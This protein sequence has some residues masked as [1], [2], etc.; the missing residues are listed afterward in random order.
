MANIRISA[1]V[2]FADGQAAPFFNVTVI[3]PGVRRYEVGLTG[4]DGT[5]EAVLRPR[6]RYNIFGFWIEDWFDQ[7]AL[8]VL[9]TD[10]DGH[11]FEAP[12]APVILLPHEF[13]IQPDEAPTDPAPAAGSASAQADAVLDAQVTPNAPGHVFLIRRDGAVWVDATQGL[14][15]VARAGLS[16][17]AM[18]N[19]TI[20]HLASM[21]K[22]I[23]ATAFVAMLDDWA[24]IR[25][26]VAALGTVG[27]PTQ[28]VRLLY[29]LW[30]FRVYR[31]YDVPTVLLPLFT[32]RE[33]ARSFLDAGLPPAVGAN[34]RTA[35]EHFVAGWR[36]V[37]PMPAVAPGHFGLLRRVL[38]GVAVPNYADPFLPLIAARLALG[39]SVG[40]NVDTITLDDLLRHRTDLTSRSPNPALHTAAEIAA[41]Q[42]TEPEGGLATDPYWAWLRLLLA[43]PANQVGFTDY[44]NNNFR[45]LTA[46]IE[47]C[48]DT[49]FDDY[50]TRRL[51]FD[52]R[53][54]RIR[55]R[56]VEPGMGA[57]YYNGTAP[58][59]TRGGLLS[60]YSNFGGHG[61]FYGTANQITDWLTALYTGET[62][63]RVGG[64]APLISAI[65]L[66]NLFDTV[67]YFSLGITNRA[68]PASAATRF[69]HNGGTGNAVGAINGNLAIVVTP[70]GVVHA[71]LFV[72]NGNVAAD[73][74]FEGAIAAL[75]WT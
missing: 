9:I 13:D 41:V 28:K 52:D 57:L 58:N 43:E 8:R 4:A 3:E 15:R 70:S 16:A 32:D 20:V 7:P 42:S 18:T 71:A 55:R 48:A 35:L 68:G 34:I 23:T 64:D 46:V 36:V 24:A 38:D 66:T 60:D 61:G 25:D 65:G 19:D 62:V 75:T 21:S 1:R 50:V 51:F 12:A 54:S 31:E 30:I 47:A 74:P 53:F 73:P 45:V 72:A 59:W 26:A 33:R 2:L 44:G 11:S 10:Y 6:R 27:A 56:V 14:A 17:R 37:S 49:T 69:Q 22:P 67:G 40:T 5:I 63:A 39:G 29:R